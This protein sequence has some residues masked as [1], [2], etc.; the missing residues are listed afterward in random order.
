M[1]KNSF[2]IF[3]LAGLDNREGD[4]TLNQ[5]VKLLEE[6]SLLKV[7]GFRYMEDDALVRAIE[8]SKRQMYIVLFS[9][10]ARESDYIAEA[11]LKK[12]YDLKNIFIVEPY[13]T[14]DYVASNVRL[15]VELGVPEINVMVGTGSST[16]RGVVQNPTPTP[17]CSPSH[18]CSLKE[19]GKTIRIKRRKKVFLIFGVVA[20]LVVGLVIFRIKTK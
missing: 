18:W 8:Q 9:A 13:A 11:F 17:E 2:P 3:L 5:Q 20:L 19:V 1:F 6:S 10:G 12:G 16:G 7:K 14:S 15:A 4:L